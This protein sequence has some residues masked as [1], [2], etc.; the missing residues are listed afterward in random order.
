MSMLKYELFTDL[1]N[2][3]LWISYRSVLATVKMTTSDPSLLAVPPV[4]VYESVVLMSPW[5]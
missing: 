3:R 1:Y 4:R 2:K 5:R